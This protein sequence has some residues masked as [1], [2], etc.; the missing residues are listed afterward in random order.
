MPKDKNGKITA[1]PYITEAQLKAIYPNCSAEKIK[2]YTAAFNVV[3]PIFEVNTPARIAAFLGQVAVESGELKYDKELGSKYNKKNP[4]DPKEPIGTLYEGRKLLGNTVAGD[5]PRF[6]GRGVLQLTGRANYTDMSKKI[7]IDLVA[8][9]EKAAEAD[10]SVRIA[11]QFFK[12]RKLFDRADSWDLRE[13]TR[14]VNG[15]ACLHHEQR[16]A[17]S[18]KALKIL[19][20]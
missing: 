16:V 3:F 1:A 15:N 11:C 19:T 20:A 13:I 5:G 2:S 6:I 7:G 18:E 10:V 12:D 8:N 14:R 9:P 4:K 17:Y